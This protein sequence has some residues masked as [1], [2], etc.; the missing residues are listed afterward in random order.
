MSLIH[1]RCQTFEQPVLEPST[2]NRR[3]AESCPQE[4]GTEPG[5]QPPPPGS[6]ILPQAPL[7]LPRLHPSP[8]PREGLP[9]P[10]SSETSLPLLLLHFQF[11]NS[12]GWNVRLWVYLVRG[13]CGTSRPTRCWWGGCRYR[14]ASD[15]DDRPVTIH[16]HREARVPGFDAQQPR[17]RGAG[18]GA[19][20]SQVLRMVSSFWDN[21]PWLCPTAA[22]RGHTDTA[23]SSR[24]GPPFA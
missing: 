4:P 11:S 12:W 14:T 3:E 17:G 22:L 13:V 7:P 10:S 23:R 15:T 9:P 19:H 2:E 16:R 1:F 8:H 18:Q 21:L 24:P 20:C 6:P 5:P